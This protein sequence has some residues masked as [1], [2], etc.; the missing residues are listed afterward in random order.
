MSDYV[1]LVCEANHVIVGVAVFISVATQSQALMVLLLWGKMSHDHAF[2]VTRGEE[3]GDKE[4]HG[5]S[6]IF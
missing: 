2:A 6:V 4:E 5:A 3:G 1:A